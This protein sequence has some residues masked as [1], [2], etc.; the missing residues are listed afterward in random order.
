MPKKVY[1]INATAMCK[2]ENIF[3]I[4][5]SWDEPVVNPDGYL[6]DICSPSV[7]DCKY[8][9]SKNV[10]GVSEYLTQQI[11]VSSVMI[12]N[13]YILFRISPRPLSRTL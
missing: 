11:Y 5:V 10:S 12:R 3:Y 2:V 6:V 13:L 7:D 9:D 8:R 1:G 4:Y